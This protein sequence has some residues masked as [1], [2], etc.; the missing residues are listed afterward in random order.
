MNKKMKSILAV[1][2]FTVCVTGASQV[3]AIG[4]GAY[5]GISAGDI[6]EDTSSQIWRWSRRLCEFIFVSFCFA[7][8]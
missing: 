5:G 1:L 3:S 4:L 7:A 6:G 8:A 2:V